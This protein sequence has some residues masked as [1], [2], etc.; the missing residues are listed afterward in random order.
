MV[1]FHLQ[2]L[3]N[4]GSFQLEALL[5]QHAASKF[6]KKREKAGIK[7]THQL[8]NALASTCHPSL[9]SMFHWLEE[10]NGFA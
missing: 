7:L 2:W 1:P 10:S 8:L 9:P 5:S 3:R 4:S 6:A